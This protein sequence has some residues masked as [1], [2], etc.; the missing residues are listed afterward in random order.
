MWPEYQGKIYL[1]TQKKEFDFPG[2]NIICTKTGATKGF[3]NDLL[4]GLAIVEEENILFLMIDY[5]FMG[6]VDHEKLKEYYQHF[7]Q[8]NLDSLVLCCHNW[9]NSNPSKHHD[10]K[11]FLPPLKENTI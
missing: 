9:E 7:I 8:S 1:N 11:R 4:S 3:G 5:I 6:K 2:L 10:F